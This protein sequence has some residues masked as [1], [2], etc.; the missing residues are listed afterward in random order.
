MIE[1][2]GRSW[3]LAIEQA[4]VAT[5]N[6]AEP[7]PERFLCMGNTNQLFKFNTAG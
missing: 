1:F 7:N 4:S 2:M 5:R 3:P 6:I